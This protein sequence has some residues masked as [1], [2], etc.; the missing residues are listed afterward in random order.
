MNEY[1]VTP[2]AAAGPGLAGRGIETVEAAAIRRIAP[3]PV[4][5]ELV[6][7]QCGHDEILH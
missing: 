2:G 6:A 1:G 4:D 7:R 5:I 3:G